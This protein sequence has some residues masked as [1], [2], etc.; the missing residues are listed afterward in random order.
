MTQPSEGSMKVVV[1]GGNGFLGLSIVQALIDA[2]RVPTCGRRKR[3][4]VL[5]LRAMKVPLVHAD[6]DAPESMQMALAGAETVVHVAGHY[7]RL[8]IDK[9]GTIALATRQMRT[10][11]D[12]VALSGARR[13]VYLSST[14]SVAKRADGTPSNEDDRY[15]A[16]PGF[17]TYHDV[18]FALEKLAEEETRFEVITL[19]PGACIGPHDYRLGT[20]AFL[21]ATA[22]G[23]QPQHPDGLVNVVDVRDV[24]LAVA[25]CVTMDS[26]PKRVILSGSTW[27]LHTLLEQ[28]APR[29]GAPP[30]VP[31]LN[32]TAA[33]AL[34]DEE[35]HRALATKTRASLSRELVDLVVHAVPV[36][37]SRSR[38][39]LG[40]VYRPL[41]E[42]VDAFDEW[43][44]K[45]GLLTAPTSPPASPSPA[46]AQRTT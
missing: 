22:R 9:E 7:P 45:I 28:L 36:D 16:P 5:G 33:I 3:S 20:A 40:L 44:K 23:M 30:P 12:S 27:N 21:A 18:K 15:N 31:A 38:N 19:C 24:G 46:V 37:T 41:A 4:N 29:Y 35:E 17:G 26:P 2:G 42:T 13:L 43:A 14:A 6:L 39:E 8:S 1:L 32:A 11:L 10:L 25:R 34:A